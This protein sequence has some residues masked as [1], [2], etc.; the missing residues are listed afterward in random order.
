MAGYL[1]AILGVILLL[2]SPCAADAQVRLIIAQTGAKGSPDEIGITEFATM[3]RSLSGGQI[4]INILPL[5][6]ESVPQAIASSQ[7]HIGILSYS[8]FLKTT[9]GFAIFDVPFLFSDRQHADA[10]LLGK[11]GTSLLTESSDANTLSLAFLERGFLQLS[12][13]GRK[14]GRPEDLQ[15]LKL[16]LGHPSE[17]AF[18][19][20]GA[21]RVAVAPAEQFTALQSGIVEGAEVTIGGFKDRKLFDVQKV[22]NLT[23]HRYIPLVLVASTSAYDLFP[24]NTRALIRDAASRSALKQRALVRD[25]ELSALM[26]IRERAEISPLA[27]RG[28]FVKALGPIYE[29]LRERAGPQLVDSI[30]KSAQ[31]CIYPPICGKPWR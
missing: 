21:N 9:P 19:L 15:G 30:L 7:V 20:L 22:L 17:A 10:I 2:A 12:T 29:S 11:I 13:R 23:S 18:K 25:L 6:P 4:Q 26:E 8:E 28:A 14:I 24:A 5:P 31:Q 3:I 27:D 16:S 1:I